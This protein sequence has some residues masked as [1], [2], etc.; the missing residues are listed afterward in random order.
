MAGDGEQGTWHTRQSWKVQAS[1]T[2]SGNDLSCMTYMYTI[3]TIV[4]YLRLHL[5]VSSNFNKSEHTLRCAQY[6]QYNLYYTHYGV[7]MKAQ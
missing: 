3:A 5:R 7:D 1:R 4:S 2:F 6:T